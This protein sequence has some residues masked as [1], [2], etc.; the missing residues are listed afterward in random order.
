MWLLDV[1]LPTRLTELLRGYGIHAETTAAR[2]WRALTNGELA[3]AAARA[4]FTVV[5]TRDRAFG[6]A[7]GLAL[8]DLSDLAIVIVTLRQA[9]EAAYLSAFDI[10][11]SRQRIE[12]TRG[13]VIEWP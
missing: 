12:P 6:A 1:N 10:A 4:G 8:Q 9:R 7:A 5:L 13:A 11:W 2:G 3:R